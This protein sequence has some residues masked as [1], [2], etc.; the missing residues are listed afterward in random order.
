MN[1]ESKP[2][3][4]SPAKKAAAEAAGARRGALN[5]HVFLCNP[6]SGDAGLRFKGHWRKTSYG[7]N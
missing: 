3:A 2:A 6:H 7:Y 1:H 5:H 4:P